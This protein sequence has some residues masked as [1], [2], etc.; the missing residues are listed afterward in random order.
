MEPTKENSCF[1]SK[2]SYQ[3]LPHSHFY[4]SFFFLSLLYFLFLFYIS[5]FIGLYI[6]IFFFSSFHFFVI[7]LSSLS[8]FAAF[9]S[10]VLFVV[11]FWFL[12]TLCVH[13]SIYLIVTILIYFSCMYCI[14]IFDICGEDSRYAYCIQSKPFVVFFYTAI[15][16]SKLKIENWLDPILNELLSISSRGVVT[17]VETHHMVDR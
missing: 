2:T 11:C 3:L 8:S 6:Y 7:S 15:K 1:L 14:C 5:Y 13:V 9:V 10:L 4:F 16:Y 17:R 12:V